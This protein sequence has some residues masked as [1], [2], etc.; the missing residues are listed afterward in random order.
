[1][2]LIPLLNFGQTETNV[3]VQNNTTV[4]SGGGYYG[5]IMDKANADNSESSAPQFDSINRI[6]EG[7]I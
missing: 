6:S 1:M 3:N 5:S 2:I 4:K 7:A